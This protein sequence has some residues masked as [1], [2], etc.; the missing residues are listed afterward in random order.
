M[1]TLQPFTSNLQNIQAHI[2]YK[3]LF[4]MTTQKFLSPP[5]NHYTIASLV[6]K[7]RA[8]TTAEQFNIR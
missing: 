1:K 6:K 3:S 2:V 7:N 8:V 5:Q 4:E